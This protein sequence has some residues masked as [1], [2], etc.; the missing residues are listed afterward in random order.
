MSMQIV[1]STHSSSY[2]HHECTDQGFTNLWID[3]ADR[4][5]I[6]NTRTHPCCSPKEQCSTTSTTLHWL[7][8]SPILLHSP[9]S[10]TDSLQFWVNL[11]KDS[12]HWSGH[13]FYS[14]YTPSQF[15]FIY[16]LLHYMNSSSTL[17]SFLLFVLNSIATWIYTFKNQLSFA[18]SQLK[19]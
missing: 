18:N 13:S 1:A 10:T 5:P 15:H 4:A 3:N 14:P 8:L 9:L 12:R 7:T 2:F 11:R 17:S 16:Q 6:T 19:E